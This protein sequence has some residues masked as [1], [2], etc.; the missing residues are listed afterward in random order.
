MATGA[1]DGED[2]SLAHLFGM[3]VR[4]SH[5]GHGLGTS[6]AAAVVDWAGLSGFERLVLQVTLANFSARSV[7]ERLGFKEVPDA[8]RPLREG[9]GLTTTTM[10]RL[11]I[12]A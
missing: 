2:A 8:T 1:G 5:R 4:M 3:F 7:Y 10:E 9:S 11:L 6:L 12:D